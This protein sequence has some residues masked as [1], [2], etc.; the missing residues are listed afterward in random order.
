MPSNQNIVFPKVAGAVNIFSTTCNDERGQS[1]M[2]LG[3]SSGT[4]G[5]AMYLSR[6][7]PCIQ[8]SD[9]FFLRLVEVYK[10]CISTKFSGE[11][12]VFD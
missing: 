6:H 2:Q 12:K 3:K 1:I 9:F 11:R 8:L 5:S 4:L 10:T 7:K